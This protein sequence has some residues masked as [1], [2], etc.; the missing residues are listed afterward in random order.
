MNPFE[1]PAKKTR[2]RII[3]QVGVGAANDYLFSSLYKYFHICSPNPGDPHTHFNAHL[4]YSYLHKKLFASPGEK[5]L[6]CFISIS[7]GRDGHVSS[8]V[9]GDMFCVSGNIYII[10]WCLRLTP[11]RDRISNIIPGNSKMSMDSVEIYYMQAGDFYLRSYTDV[12]I[13]F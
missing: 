10:A 9:R 11:V 7:H 12:H 2:C 3:Q 1:I 5:S 8:Y 6:K 4:C 13:Y